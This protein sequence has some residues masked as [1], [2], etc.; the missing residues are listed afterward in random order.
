MPRFL[1]GAL[2]P[3]PDH[4]DLLP[5]IRADGTFVEWRTIQFS[6]SAPILE[7]SISDFLAETTMAARRQVFKQWVALD[8]SKPRSGSTGPT[9]FR[10]PASYRVNEDPSQSFGEM[11]NAVPELQ[12]MARGVL[13][14]PSA[15]NALAGSSV[16]GVSCRCFV[17]GSI[18]RLSAPRLRKSV[19]WSTSV[20]GQIAS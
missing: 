18:R 12:H 1:A 2:L 11:G 3:L 17:C 13:T 8:R 19:R 14:G 15:L 5:E 16:V 7:I 20:A 4:L 10:M 6:L 9:R